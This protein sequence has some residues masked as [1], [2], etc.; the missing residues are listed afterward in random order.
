M[1]HFSPYIIEQRWPTLHPDR[2]QLYSFPTPNGVKVSA[3]LEEMELPYEVHPVNIL[4][5]AT[6]TPEFLSLNPNGKI[7]A[8][9]DPDGP[10]GKPLGL[11]E[12]CT[13]LQYLAQ[14][15]GRLI[16]SDPARQW[17]TAQ[18]LDFQ[19]AGV[20]PIFGQLGFFHKFAGREIEDKRALNRYVDETKRLLGV[21]DA[22]L[23]GRDWIMDEF[24]IADLSMLFW[25]DALTG[26]YEA[27]ELVGMQS[28]GRVQDWVRRGLERPAVK[29]ARNIPPRP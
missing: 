21:I 2:I 29:R 16:S 13:I 17:E 19:A 8:I 10:S 7:P 26:F 5:N 14:K 1:A 9:I 6:R 20:G 15:S 24:S 4:S 18:W 28:F 23:E 3:A 25:V 27:D 12:S 22:R 11:F